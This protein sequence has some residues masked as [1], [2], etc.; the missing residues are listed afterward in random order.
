M[1]LIK[2]QQV[3]SLFFTPEVLEYFWSRIV[4]YYPVLYF[5]RTWSYMTFVA[6]IS[7]AIG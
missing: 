4:H 3:P 6:L 1:V 7:I 5:Q 2:W